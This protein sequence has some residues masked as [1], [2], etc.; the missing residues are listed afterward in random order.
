MKLRRIIA[1]IATAAVVAFG[2]VTGG[3]ANFPFSADTVA[4][5]A[6]V[7]DLDI[8]MSGY[9]AYNVTPEE[10]T[11]IPIWFKGSGISRVGGS[12]TN[13]AYKVWF[14]NIEWRAY[15]EW[16]LA[17][18][19]LTAPSGAGSGS[20]TLYLYDDYSNIIGTYTTNITVAETSFEFS[21]M[22]V[23][24][25]ITYGNCF[26]LGG[27]ITCS[28]ELSSVKGEV[29]DSSGNVVLKA[30]SAASGKSFDIRSSSVNSRLTFGS[31]SAGSY[32]LRYTA[33]ASDGSISVKEYCFS[34]K[35]RFSAS[36]NEDTVYNFLVN[37]MGYSKAAAIG[38]IANIAAESGFN[39]NI[40]GDS[41]TSY[42]ICQWHNSRFTA[43]KSFC[44]KHGLD[45]TDIQDQLQYLKYELEGT[46]VDR[47]LRTVSNDRNG[48]YNAAYYFC[49]HF[50]R[51]ANTN[52]TSIKRGNSAMN[53]YWFRH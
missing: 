9:E 5:A 16:C 40:Y 8:T 24:T 2:S 33:T 38:V 18:I 19:S 32:T 41:G 23:P 10:P 48:A 30:N 47:Y 42:G 14:S 29:I 35:P 20:V 7:L 13:S 44:S 6:T 51:P 21:N 3:P 28:T 46:S 37:D 1:P 15:P 36:Q 53:T 49:Y 26:N 27:T 52:N 25:D 17:E 50:E 45:Y 22:V 34:V 43:L 12:Y 11:T 39:P 31:L 4:S